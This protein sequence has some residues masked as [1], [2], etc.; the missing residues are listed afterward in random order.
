M[1]VKYTFPLFICR[2]VFFET[3]CDVTERMLEV[4]FVWIS[5]KKKKKRFIVQLFSFF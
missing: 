3:K 4:D 2:Y 1:F 5:N